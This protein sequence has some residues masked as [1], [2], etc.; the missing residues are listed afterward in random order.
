MTTTRKSLFIVAAIVVIIGTQQLAQADPLVLSLQNNAQG[1]A[2]GSVTMFASATNTG[3]TN[4]NTL[5]IVVLA[6]Q[7]PDPNWDID[8]TPYRVN[9][10]YQQ[11]PSGVTLGPLPLLIFNIGSGVRDGIYSGPLWLTYTG[12]NGCIT[13]EPLF[14]ATVEWTIVVGPAPA[15]VPEPTTIVLLSIGLI[16][17]AAKVRRRL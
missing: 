12:V 1:V 13:C 5:R 8:S 4:T 6:L 15:P 7:I 16:G 14:T 2:G 9:W 17:I 10:E 3:T 11:V